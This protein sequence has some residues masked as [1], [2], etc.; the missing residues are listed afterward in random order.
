MKII[1]SII[2]MQQYS[3]QLKSKGK[4]LANVSTTG[5]LHKGHMHLVDIAKENADEVVVNIDH[6]DPYHRFKQEPHKYDEYLE[7][8]RTEQLD[9]DLE[10]CEK[11]GVDIFFHPDIHK[12]YISQTN[13]IHSNIKKLRKSYPGVNFVD[14]GISKS[15]LKDFN[16]MMPDIIMMGQKDIL[17]NLEAQFMITDFNFPI[18]MI[19]API[20]RESDGLA[21]S[22][23]LERLSE[24]ERKDARSIYESL[25]EIEEWVQQP[26][27]PSIPDMKEHIRNRITD[28]NGSVNYLVIC[29]AVTLEELRYFDRKAIIVVD[30]TFGKNIALSDNIIIEPK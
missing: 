19:M 4:T 17:Q 8:Y 26:N 21:S 5:F 18:K 10:L 9:K 22:S 6:I 29:C 16:M 20:V 7:E 2:E 12:V 25:K 30:A 1:E 24:F 11:H 14:P 28:A 13:Q 23:R 27:G 3:I 15:N